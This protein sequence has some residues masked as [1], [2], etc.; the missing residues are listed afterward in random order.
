MVVIVSVFVHHIYQCRNTISTTT[1]RSNSIGTAEALQ[2]PRTQI[3]LVLAGL[4][5]AV[6]WALVETI[7]I[8]N[9]ATE[10]GCQYESLMKGMTSSCIIFTTCVL[11][12]SAYYI[13]PKLGN[14][15]PSPKPAPTLLSTI[16]SSVSA[17]Q[18]DSADISLCNTRNDNITS[19]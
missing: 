7:P 12:G 5:G 6:S 11:G 3:V 2:N 15:L 8:Y 18:S 16:S 4:R 19:P 1:S 14:T 13:I 17:T 9:I 10:E